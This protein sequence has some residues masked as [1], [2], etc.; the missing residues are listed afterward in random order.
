MSDQAN[1]DREAEDWA[2]FWQENADTSPPASDVEQTDAGELIEEG[3][4]QV[5]MSFLTNMALAADNIAPKANARLSQLAI[6]ALLAL[7]LAFEAI[8]HWCSWFC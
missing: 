3:I 6:N 7:F 5:A 4:R 8:G 2:T 1:V